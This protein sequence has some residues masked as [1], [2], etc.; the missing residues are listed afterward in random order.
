MIWK[1]EWNAIAARIDALADGSRFLL[2][3]FKAA[4][5]DC[6]AHGC[7]PH[8][9][10]P[11][12]RG[13]ACELVRFHDRHRE[14]FP[15]AAL[16][17]LQG[18]L[19]RAE[20]IVPDANSGADL[21]PIVWF[22]LFRSQFEYALRDCEAPVIALT[23]RAFQHLQRLIVADTVVRERWQDAFAQTRAEESCE[24]LG[25]AHLLHHGIFG[26]KI[27]GSGDARGSGEVTDLVFQEPVR[28]ADG[29]NRIADGLVLTEWKRVTA[30]NVD[31]KTEE[32]IA[33][34][35]CYSGGVLGGAELRRTRYIVAVSRD[36]I[37]PPFQKQ[38]GTTTYRRVSIRVSPKTA[39]VSARKK[40]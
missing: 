32:A 2:D 35:E 18:F 26:F 12:A 28:D 4:G 20:G 10:M 3:A 17:L 24:K 9:I 19:Q 33:Q 14:K 37:P 1:A 34:A 40:P 30:K 21:Q 13:I 27:H 38:L 7:V 8:C 6:D 22:Q 31:R 39:S 23:E 16:S 11:E 5:S 25:G 15:A 29:I 36:Y